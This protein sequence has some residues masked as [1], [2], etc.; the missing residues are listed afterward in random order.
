AVLAPACP[1][2]VVYAPS[3]SVV[4]PW[5]EA[6]R[7]ALPPPHKVG[8]DAKTRLQEWLQRGQKPLPVYTLLEESGDEHARHFRVSCTLALPPVRSEGE[9][10][11][12]RAA[13]RGAAA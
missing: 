2:A 3:G 9:G 8:K 13:E 11:S 6:A 5:C 4:R 7:P 12:R 1:W 10:H